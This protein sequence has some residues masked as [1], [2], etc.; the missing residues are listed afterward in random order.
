MG[1][2]FARFAHILSS[3]HSAP[4]LASIVFTSE[5]W[6]TCGCSPSGLWVDVDEWLVRM[7]MQTKVKGGLAVI[8]VQR[9]EDDPVSSG[10]FPKFRKAGGEV[11]V[12]IEEAIADDDDDGDDD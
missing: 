10:C 2:P 12:R 9:P 5:W 1:E 8:L 4:A 3:I 11:R 7:A 6:P